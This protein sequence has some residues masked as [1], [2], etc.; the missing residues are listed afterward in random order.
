MDKVMLEVVEIPDHV[1]YSA[2]GFKDGE[3][4]GS[5]ESQRRASNPQPS[6]YEAGARPVVLRWRKETSEM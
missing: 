4:H 5:E 2:A 1:F 6:A 3:W